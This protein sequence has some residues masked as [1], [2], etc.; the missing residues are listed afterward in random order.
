MAE[1]RNAATKTTKKINRGY[2][3]KSQHGSSG[4]ASGSR[5]LSIK[6]YKRGRRRPTLT[7]Q[8][9]LEIAHQC[10]VG[11]R[12]WADVAKEHRVS[13]GTVSMLVTKVKRKPQV[14]SELFVL[15]DL[16]GQKQ[17]IVEGVVDSLTRS[18]AFIDSCTSVVDK[19]K[20]VDVGNTEASIMKAEVIKDIKA[21]EVRKTMLEMGLRYKKVNQI[22]MT[23]NSER[24]LVLRQQ[25][26][27][28]L[29][30]QNPQNKVLLNLDET[31]LGMSD[32]RRRKWQ[33]PGSNNSVAAFQLTPRVSMLTAVDT[34]GNVYMALAQSNSN[35]QMMSLFWKGLCMK[36][37]RERP[38]WRSNTLWTLDGAAYHSGEE[39]L[40]TL[41]A[42]K[43]PVLMQGPHS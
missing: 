38:G 29:L 22:A 17:N 20:R 15:R 26:A 13:V 30:K 21:D 8:E 11:Q 33:A 19:V 27:I 24:S 9:K 1:V 14:I 37:D 6:D 32:W 43:V 4:K 34:L 18:N 25:F 10:I 12:K 39:S 3:R 28:K 2:A 7:Q 36:L 41:R 40:N 5:D 16:K 23:A 31:W 35:Q 42:L